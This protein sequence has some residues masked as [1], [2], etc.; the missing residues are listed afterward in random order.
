MAQRTAARSPSRR[1]GRPDAAKAARAATPA[2][3]LQTLRIDLREFVRGDFPDL[4]RLD[5]D[6]RVVRYVGNGKPVPPADVARMLTRIMG[7]GRLYP[8]L[9]IWYATRRDTG[10]FIGWFSLKYCGKSPEVEIG[11][12]LLHDAWGLGFATEGATA[13]LHYGFD[14][15]TLE[16]IIGVTHPDNRASQHVLQKAGLADAGWGR[17]YDRRLRLFVALR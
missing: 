14:D 5:A 16:R 8:D 11:Y 7:Y 13:L 2:P 1:A 6:P 4:C 12:R 10:A 3:W 17:Y 15:L 9:G